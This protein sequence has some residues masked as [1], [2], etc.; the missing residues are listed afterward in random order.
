[1]VSQRQLA[2]LDQ[3]D[4]FGALLPRLVEIVPPADRGQLPLIG[5]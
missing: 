1:M 5:H 3:S 2:E 4:D